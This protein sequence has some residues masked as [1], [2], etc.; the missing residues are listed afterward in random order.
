VKLLAFASF[1]TTLGGFGPLT[2]EI[3]IGMMLRL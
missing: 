3:P 2:G 1:S